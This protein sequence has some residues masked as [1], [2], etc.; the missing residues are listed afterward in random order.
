MNV[1]QKFNENT[2]NNPPRELYI[3]AIKLIKTQHPNCLDIAAGA[4]NE[5]KDML[6]RGCKVTA[7][8]S[9]DQITQLAKQ[10]TTTNLTTVVSTMEDYK[11]GQNKFDFIVAM[12]AL[13][14]ITQEKFENTFL[15]ITL[16][17]KKSG[18]FAFH[19]FGKNDDWSKN[20]KMAFHDKDSIDKLLKNVRILKLK[21]IEDKGETANGQDKHWHIFQVIIRK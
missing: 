2:K 20:K 14:F 1:W 15:N 3:E 6:K 13:P 11:Y 10:I 19:L 16:S 9:N 18:I 21:E 12:F 7:I 4:L 17:L 5:T 8:D